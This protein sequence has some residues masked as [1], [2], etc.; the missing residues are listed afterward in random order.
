MG[1]G[2]ETK[3]AALQSKRERQ[4]ILDG[5]E[6][7]NDYGHAAIAVTPLLETIDKL[8]AELKRLEDVL[9]KMAAEDEDVKLL[10][11]MPGMGL[12]TASTIRAYTDDI[13][14]YRSAK[15]YA[16]YIGLAPWV[17]N[18]NKSIHHGHITKR[19][20]VEMRTAF[21]QLPMG[22]IR[23]ARKTER[24]RIMQ[25]YRYMKDQKGTGTSIIATSRKLTTIVYA[26][27][28]QRRAFDPGMMFSSQLEKDM[29]ATA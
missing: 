15:A 12:I 17:Q 10:M 23:A 5:L 7:H 24:F 27:L 9:S 2:I 26:M 6:D 14:R 20:P 1:Y 16:S 11:S 21:V 29:Q 4:R 13:R 18:S 25:R 19:G 28:T 3:R 8:S 22:M